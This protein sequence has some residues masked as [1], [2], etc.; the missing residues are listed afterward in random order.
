MLPARIVTYL[1][2]RRATI[3]SIFGCG[4]SNAPGAVSSPA[5]REGHF[6]LELLS[7]GYYPATDSA[8]GRKERIRRDRIRSPA[9]FAETSFQSSLRYSGRHET[10]HQPPPD[11]SLPVHHAA[12]LPRPRDARHRRLRAFHQDHAGSKGI[13]CRGR[14]RV[15]AEFPRGPEVFR[16][17]AEVPGGNGAVFPEPDRIPGADEVHGGPGCH[18]RGHRLLPQR[19]GPPHRGSDAPGTADRE[20]HH[21]PGAHADDLRQQGGPLHPR[22][23]RPGPPDRLR[24]PEGPR[25]GGGDLRRA[26]LLHRRLRGDVHGAGRIRVRHTGLRDHGPLLRRSPRR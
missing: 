9:V 17:G 1:Y 25:R 6:S 24:A 10:S 23:G 16:G 21:Q 11:G 19:T 14:P 20:P 15:G 4:T 8:S 22:R 5:A 12:G 26:V 13:L 2:C 7:R 18:A 3:S